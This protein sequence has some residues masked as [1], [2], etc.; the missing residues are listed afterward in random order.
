MNIAEE[1]VAADWDP[2]NPSDECLEATKRPA[3]PDWL[4]EMDRLGIHHNILCLV[5]FSRFARGTHDGDSRWEDLMGLALYYALACEH[6][7]HEF[8]RDMVQGWAA[9]LNAWRVEVLR[10]ASERLDTVSGDEL[11]ENWRAYEPAATLAHFTVNMGLVSTEVDRQLMSI[12]RSMHEADSAEPDEIL[13]TNDQE[14]RAYHAFLTAEGT[15]AR[16]SAEGKIEIDPL[17]VKTRLDKTLKRVI[18]PKGGT[19]EPEQDKELEEVIA[20]L[21]VTEQADVVRRIRDARLAE[22]RPGSARWHVLRHF[23]ELVNGDTTFRDLAATVELSPSALHE[24]F[25]G[26]T[27]AIR[28]LLE[29]A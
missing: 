17:I 27:A 22:A 7:P 29:A 4:T 13:A 10:P 16:I 25:T 23:D 18:Q 28:Q 19:P 8:T 6:E 24:A 21:A 2:F 3:M 15:V 5:L 12:G 14:L 11:R 9:K 20:A 26:E 1:L